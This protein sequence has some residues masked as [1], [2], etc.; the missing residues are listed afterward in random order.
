MADRIKK[1]QRLEGYILASV[2]LSE[3]KRSCLH[4]SGSMQMRTK[5]EPVDLKWSAPVACTSVKEVFPLGEKQTNH[6]FD[7]EKGLLT[8]KPF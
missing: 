5:D 4:F 2:L 1:G 8:L 6:N 7:L 3:R